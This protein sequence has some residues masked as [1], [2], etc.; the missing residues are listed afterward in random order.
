MADAARILELV[1]YYADQGE[2][3]PRTPGELYERIRDF[4]VLEEDG[5]VIGCGALH[6]FWKD[7]GELRSLAMEPSRRGEGLGGK[8]V[9]HLLNEARR[10]G[11]KRV[12]ALTYRTGFF[13][14]LGFEAIEKEALPHKIWTDC[15]NCPR[16]ASCDE[17]AMITYLGEE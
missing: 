2:M 16:F 3:L 4:V 13:G 5:R 6:I 9:A 1:N 17:A 15:V 8:L 12:F 11:L 10:L 14:R 7:L